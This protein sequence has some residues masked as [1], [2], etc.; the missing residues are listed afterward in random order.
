[1]T[2]FAAALNIG[3]SSIKLAVY[4][5]DQ[6]AERTPPAPFLSARRTVNGPAALD[7]ALNDVLRQAKARLREGGVAAVGHRIVHGGRDFTAPA[8]LTDAALAD[9][10]ALAPL[11]PLHQAV[12]LAGVRAAMEAWPDAAQVGCFD[13]AFHRT[14]PRVAELF[15]LPAAYADEGVI[16][17]GFHG[18]SY[19]HIAR[20]LP[21]L[22]GERPRGRVIAAHLGAGASMCAMK[23]GKSVATT[24]GF[25]ALDGLPM[26]HR[27]GAVDP[28]LV[29]HL[30][31]QR[32]MTAAE[33]RT[34]LYEQSGLLGMSGVSDDME[35]L[36]RSEDPAARL[37]IDHYV[38][39]AGREIGS[40]A[41]ALG[42]LD[43]LVFTGGVGE[44][45]PAIRAA[46]CTAADWLGV[47]A[48]EDANARGGPQIS[49]ADSAVSVWMIPANEE[50]GI[51][52]DAWRTSE[53][54]G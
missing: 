19:T 16:R 27:S 8:V 1:M 48:D 10:T 36:L 45:A 22:V 17:Y 12:N 15:A 3:S 2:R 23:G 33:V 43:A 37:A 35:M 21:G 9:L 14:Q 5:E 40:L 24:M 51:A 25:T 31:E 54:G 20:T 30:I 50:W 53:A 38:Y 26:A 44:N 42:G 7:A 47:K 39:R 13:T 28:G 49:A 18:L 6:L 34:L 46:I 11:A 41:A 52:S 29:L 4:S 32:G